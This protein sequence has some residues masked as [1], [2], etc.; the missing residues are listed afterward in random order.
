MK[1]NGFFASMA[2][3]LFLM[4]M[5]CAVP[6]QAFEYP[7]FTYGNL[8]NYSGGSE[9]PGTKVDAY[10]EQGIDWYQFRSNGPVLNTF[11]GLNGTFSDKSERWWDNMY[12]PA[13]G[14]K[15]KFPIRFSETSGGTFSVGVRGEHFE[16]V[17]SSALNS[18]ENRVVVFGQWYFEG[19]WSRPPANK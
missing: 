3:A 13:L 12:G 17:G 8:S 14:V 9:S 2:G 1:R 19:N 16:Y 7:W 15:M 5:A 18:S 11:V 6:V 10:I 4:S